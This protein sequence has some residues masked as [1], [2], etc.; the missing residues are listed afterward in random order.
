[1]QLVEQTTYVVSRT[2]NT[3]V[4]QSFCRSL[5]VLC[6]QCDSNRAVH[7]HKRKIGQPFT[8]AQIRTFQVAAGSVPDTIL[9]YSLI[10]LLAASHTRAG[11]CY[12]YRAL[13]CK[14]EASSAGQSLLLQTPTLKQWSISGTVTRCSPTQ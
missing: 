3:R 14:R 1:M 4:T 13:I 11:M 6:S 12:A 5:L 10:L 2:N 9:P 8:R 7:I